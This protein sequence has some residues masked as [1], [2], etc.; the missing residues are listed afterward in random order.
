[1]GDR[2]RRRPQACASV[3]TATPTTAGTA[4]CVPARRPRRTPLW[5]LVPA[6]VLEHARS[7][8]V[9][10]LYPRDLLPAGAGVDRRADA[11]RRAGAGRLLVGAPLAGRRVPRA[12]R[13][14]DAGGRGSPRALGRRGRAAGSPGDAHH[15]RQPRVAGHGAGATCWSTGSSS[16]PAAPRTA[17]AEVGVRLAIENHGDLRAQDILEVI[18]RTGADQP[19]RDAGQRQPH[20]GR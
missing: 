8:D 4:R 2:L 9:D 10:D 18:E 12:R 15:A 13:G 16:P 5:P 17:A 11:R 20:P 3:S 14:P 19:G 1:M 6:P 7:L